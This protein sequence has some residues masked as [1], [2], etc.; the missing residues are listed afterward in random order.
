MWIGCNI[1]QNATNLKA[2]YGKWKKVST[3]RTT[4]KLQSE[5]RSMWTGSNI[6]RDAA[7][8]QALYGKCLKDKTHSH[9]REITIRT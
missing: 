6:A 4:E 5:G 3:F 9:N 2:R 8:M 7:N 1:A